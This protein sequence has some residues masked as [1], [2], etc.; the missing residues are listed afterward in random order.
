MAG[1]AAPAQAPTACASPLRTLAEAPGLLS[2]DRKDR[3]DFLRYFY[4]RYE[5]ASVEQID[6]DAARAVQRRHPHQ[7]LPRG[8]P[9]GARAQGAGHRTVLI[10]GAL[11]FVVKPLEP[12]FDE[13]I[14]ARLSVDTERP[15][16]RR[17]RA[18][19]PTG[20][21]RAQLLADYC[22][23]EGLDPGGVG[24]LRRQHLRPAAARGRRLPRGGQPG[25]AA[26]GAGPQA[27]LAGGALGEGAGRAAAAAADRAGVAG[28][29]SGQR[30]GRP[31]KAL[32]VSTASW[33][34]SPR[35]AWRGRC[36][37]AAVPPSDRCELADIDPPELP[38]PGWVQL[39]PRLAGICGSRPV[40]H[41][42]RRQPL[43]R[44]D[45]Q[46]PLR[47]R[48]RGGGRHRR[49]PQSR[50][51]TGARL[52]GPRHQPAVRR[53]APGAISAAASGSPSAASSRGCRP[54]SAA[55]TGGGWGTFM[56]AH[57]SQLHPVPDGH[58]RRGRRDGRADGVRGARRAH[59]WC[60]RR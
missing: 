53:P 3:G 46:L 48:P 17:A 26:G 47:A 22:A 36:G 8:H 20:E 41:R 51:R 1:H 9:P 49:R 11:D 43:L 50:A 58:D 6:E 34:A 18:T 2:L 13:I 52:R 4:R 14:A 40:H 15:L 55:D 59:C 42:R 24:R 29:A 44:A 5:G 45:R 16:H 33:P 39:R 12:L 30:E 57:E 54:A 23:A 32:R 21:T 37:P 10:T 27:G 28:A 38:G 31:M 56:V 7:E 60:D 19:P 25:D 35:P